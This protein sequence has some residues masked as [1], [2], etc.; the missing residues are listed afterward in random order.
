MMFREQCVSR[1]FKDKIGVDP[2]RER[3]GTQS[4][5]ERLMATI[6]LVA[7][8]VPILGFSPPLHM[9]G[10]NRAASQLSRKLIHGAVQP[11]V[12]PPWSWQNANVHR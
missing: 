6:I 9:N 7:L 8:T 1:C 5:A 10:V 2:T 4:T 11:Q 3:L 12:F